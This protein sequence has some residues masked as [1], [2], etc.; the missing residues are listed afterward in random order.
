MSFDW[1]INLLQN[2]FLHSLVFVI[3]GT[4]AACFSASRAWLSRFCRFFEDLTLRYIHVFCSFEVSVQPIPDCAQLYLT[5]MHAHITKL[6]GHI[7]KKCSIEYLLNIMW[8]KIL[9][10]NDKDLLKCYIIYKKMNVYEFNGAIIF[11]NWKIEHSIQ[12]GE[13]ELNRMFNL[14]THENNHTIERMKQ[15]SLFVLYNT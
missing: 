7:T 13:A 1:R 12:R 6:H 11:M 9:Q 4:F 14:S 2:L 5:K 15:H 3:H 8:Q 10:S